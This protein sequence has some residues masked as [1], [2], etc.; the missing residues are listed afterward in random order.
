MNFFSLQKPQTP[1]LTDLTPTLYILY[2]NSIMFL[3]MAETTV[4][5]S[6]LWG[7]LCKYY[8]VC[9]IK[10][11]KNA[12]LV[13]HGVSSV[14]EPALDLFVEEGRCPLVC[15]LWLKPN[16]RVFYRNREVMM[17]PVPRQQSW[18]A[19]GSLTYQFWSGLSLNIY[20]VLR[21]GEG[22]HSN[23]SSSCSSVTAEIKY[24]SLKKFL[25]FPH[26]LIFF[27]THWRILNLRVTVLT[28]HFNTTSVRILPWI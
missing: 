19:S 28:E 24:S 14:P 12:Y 27:F 15:E 7:F 10:Q 22:K 18:N 2:R 11:K 25:L 13:H 20:K 5:S 8:H 21:L 9:C 3:S 17:F 6:F 26:I 4:L 1:L 16:K 23:D